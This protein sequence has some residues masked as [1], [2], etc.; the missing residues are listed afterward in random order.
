[1]E[2]LEFTSVDIVTYKLLFLGS[3]FY[4]IISFMKRIQNILEAYH[5]HSTLN[6]ELSEDA[7]P[8]SPVTC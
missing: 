1:M 5:K 3:P 8:V 2:I 4:A 6:W 7:A